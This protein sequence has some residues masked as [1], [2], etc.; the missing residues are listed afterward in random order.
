MKHQRQTTLNVTGMSC[1][2]CARHV[3]SS[4]QALP[5]VSQVNVQL[6]TGVVEVRHQEATTVAALLEAVREAG[7][8]SAVR[9]S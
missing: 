8:D 6:R 9:E 3:T 2:S 5:G 7:Y 1:G 4:L